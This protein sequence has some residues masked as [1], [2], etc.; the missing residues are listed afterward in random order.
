MF[1]VFFSDIKLV[2]D[3][4]YLVEH[5]LDFI[6][7]SVTNAFDSNDSSTEV[8]GEADCYVQYRFP[9]QRQGEGIFCCCLIATE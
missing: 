2:S 3:I 8:W 7:E 5:S 4:F 1:V 6:V 9:K